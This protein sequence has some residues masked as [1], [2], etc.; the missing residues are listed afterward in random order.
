METT[1][2]KL[3]GSYP[4]ARPRRL[5]RAG[6]L[7]N[8]CATAR[9]TADKLILPIFVKEGGRAEP[10]TGM[11]SVAVHPLVELPKI[12]ERAA[13]AGLAAVALFPRVPMGKKDSQGEEATRPDNLVC[14]SISMLRKELP[15]LAII[16]DVALDP[17]TDHGHDGALDKNGEV[18]NDK[19]VAA[20]R[21]QALLLAE[22][23]AAAIAPSDMMDGRIGAIRSA[24]DKA[25]HQNLPII[26]YTAKYASALY[27]PFRNAVGSAAL[28]KG[29]KRGYQLNPAN[30]KEPFRQAGMDVAQGA[31]ALIVKPALPYLD[32]VQNLSNHFPL[33]VL[34]YQVS[35]EYA[36][37]ED[38]ET[39]MECLVSIRRSGAVG[40]FSYGALRAAA[41]LKQ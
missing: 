5:R 6:W 28:L 11:E 1:I 12:A 23:G 25:G 30:P 2:S 17:Y 15:Q 18:A 22:A 36:M 40:I 20:L 16:A 21:A 10:V 27:G 7:R 3:F 4:K 38:S 37:L 14:R 33:P 31:D 24:L 26:S 41:L 29:D 8:L 34:A 32:V 19:T 39:F 9:L 35:G 13:K